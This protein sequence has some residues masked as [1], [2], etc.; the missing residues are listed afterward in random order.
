MPHHGWWS[1]SVSFPFSSLSLAVSQFLDHVRFPLYLFYNVDEQW[2]SRTGC[3]VVVIHVYLYDGIWHILAGFNE[4]IFVYQRAAWICQILLC[5]MLFI[6]WYIFIY[7]DDNN[8]YIHIKINFI[9]ICYYKMHILT[10]NKT[11]GLGFVIFTWTKYGLEYIASLLF[12]F[13]NCQRGWGIVSMWT[14]FKRLLWNTFLSTRVFFHSK[15]FFAFT[16]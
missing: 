3:T 16:A 8:I 9:H 4:L 12:L 7:I 14:E 13:F 6:I 11:N 15:L 10:E 2:G 5:T 1:S